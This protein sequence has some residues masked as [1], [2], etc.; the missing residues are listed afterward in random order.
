MRLYLRITHEN[1]SHPAVIDTDG[2]R[3]GKAKTK[4]STYLTI[5]FSY[6][7]Y[8]NTKISILWIY[9]E[10]NRNRFL[11]VTVHYIFCFQ[12]FVEIRWLP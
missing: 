3:K 9:N 6:R 4:P 11:L 2:P 8:K 12:S 7:Y 5:V 1:G 10:T